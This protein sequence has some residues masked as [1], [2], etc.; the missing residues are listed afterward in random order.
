L[1]VLLLAGLPPLVA[2]SA[3]GR[4]RVVLLFFSFSLVLLEYVLVL[5]LAS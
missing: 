2:S 1:A 3:S 4:E 5:L